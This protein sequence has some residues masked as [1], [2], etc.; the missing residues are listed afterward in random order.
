MEDQA[1][2]VELPGPDQWSLVQI[3]FPVPFEPIAKF[4]VV[5]PLPK[6]ICMGR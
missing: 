1:V 3:E 2:P 5:A 4:P 6:I